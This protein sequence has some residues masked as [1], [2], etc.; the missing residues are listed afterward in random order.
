MMPHELLSKAPPRNCRLEPVWIVHI[1]LGPEDDDRIRH[2]IG[3]AAG[4]SYGSYD[5]VSF[6]SATGIQYFRGHSG[7]ASGSMDTATWRDVRLLS[8]S[9]PRNTALLSAVL[10]LVQ[11]NHSYEEPVV[12]IFEAYA[13]RKI[14][15]KNHD[16]PNKW[17][18]KKSN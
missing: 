18:K 13:T 8:F 9:L 17:W 7:T 3:K 12:Y 16:S 10:D 15:N 14:D 2:T 1:E 11:E 6:E 4:L 5:H